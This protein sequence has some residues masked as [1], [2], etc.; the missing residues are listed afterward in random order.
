VWTPPPPPVELARGST[1]AMPGR[2]PRASWY[3]LVVAI[4]AAIVVAA[5]RG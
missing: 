4:V 2:A 3:A 5:L 1:P